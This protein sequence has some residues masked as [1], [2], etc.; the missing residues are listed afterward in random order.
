MLSTGLLL[1]LKKKTWLL[2]EAELR[3]ESI[4]FAKTA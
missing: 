1:Y 2:V 4:L 3:A